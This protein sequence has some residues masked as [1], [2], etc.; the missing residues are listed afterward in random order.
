[1]TLISS[2]FLVSDGPSHWTRAARRAHGPA[3]R[4]EPQAHWQ[5][6]A[7]PPAVPAG[8]RPGDDSDVS[9]SPKRMLAQAASPAPSGRASLLAVLRLGRGAA[10]PRPGPATRR[11][12]PG[13]R[14]LI[15]RGGRRSGPGRGA[16]AGGWPGRA[17][18]RAAGA[19]AAA[20]RPAAG[21]PGTPKDAARACLCVCVRARVLACVRARVRGAEPLP[22]IRPTPHS[23]AAGS[24]SRP[25]ASPATRQQ[26][27]PHRAPPHRSPVPSPCP[28][29]ACPGLPRPAR[30]RPAPA[31]PHLLAAA[32]AVEA[33]VAR[34][35]EPLQQVPGVDTCSSLSLSPPPLSLS[36]PPSLSLSLISPSPSPAPS[37]ALPLPPSRSPP[38]PPPLPLSPLQQVPGVDTCED[39]SESTLSLPL[40]PSLSLSLSFSLSLSLSLSAWRV[41]T[42]LLLLLRALS[43]YFSA[44]S[45]LPSCI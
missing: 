23:H 36:L 39:Q 10:G 27:A 9:R 40:S 18:R 4:R 5:A 26:P 25:Q 22:G 34:V 35:V 1:M 21:G 38:L 20:R 45:N 7:P 33:G 15:R 19:P 29:P 11:R 12:W 24:R 32:R 3:G 16:A 14:G 2:Q 17:R 31:R 13:G 41:V 42:S 44:S 43:R 37:L 8:P 30:P 6:A 28:R